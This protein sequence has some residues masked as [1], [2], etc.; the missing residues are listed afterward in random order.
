M[1]SK[2]RVFLIGNL[3]KDPQSGK[4][5]K[6]MVTFSIATHE[7]WKGDDGKPQKK[8]DWHNIVAFGK[9]AELCSKYVKKGSKVCI[10]GRLQTREYT[11]EGEKKYFTEVVANEVTFLDPREKGDDAAE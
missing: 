10:E 6:P 11:V 3:G 9:L 4:G 2:N 8:T 1:S 7:T 5:E